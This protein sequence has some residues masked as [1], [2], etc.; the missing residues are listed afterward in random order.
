MISRTKDQR[1]HSTNSA[2]EVAATRIVQAGP[3]PMAVYRD[4][5]SKPFTFAFANFSAR[6]SRSSQPWSVCA[7]LFPPV[8]RC[9]A[10]ATARRSMAMFN[11]SE[12]SGQMVRRSTGAGGDGEAARRLMGSPSSA[13]GCEGREGRV[14][15][16]LVSDSGPFGGALGGVEGAPCSTATCILERSSARRRRRRLARRRL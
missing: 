5:R 12:A 15:G 10:R 3:H 9:V 4:S 11:A 7:A 16:V 13:T 1:G 8:A 2:S 14:A 6:H